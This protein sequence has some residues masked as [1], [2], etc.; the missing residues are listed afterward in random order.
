MNPT[1]IVALDVGGRRIGV[2]RGN[3]LAKLPEPLP[4]I[5]R[6]D[7]ND[8]AKIAQILQSYSPDLIVVGLP[9]SLSSEDSEQTKITHQ[10][11][12]SL[13]K[14]LKIKVSL[15]DETLSTVE[16]QKW[17]AKFPEAAEDSLA[18]CVILERYFEGEKI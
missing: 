15:C 8:M 12:E 14:E 13:A 6:N 2:A 7:V 1:E 9:K 3:S 18:A 5:D 10:F 17:L 11:A 4:V 16:A